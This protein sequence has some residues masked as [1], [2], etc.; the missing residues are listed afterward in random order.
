MPKPLRYDDELADHK[1]DLIHQILS[2][3]YLA[4]REGLPTRARSMESLLPKDVADLEKIRTDLH[5]L[6]Y[7]PPPRK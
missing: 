6:V 7:A 1:I 4:K 2:L 3:N 5:E